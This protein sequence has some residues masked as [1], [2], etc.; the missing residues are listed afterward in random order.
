M[1]KI[2]E[3]KW[4]ESSQ[5]DVVRGEMGEPLGGR[6]G[7]NSSAHYLICGNCSPEPLDHMTAVYMKVRKVGW[8]MKRDGGEVHVD[9][10]ECPKCGMQVLR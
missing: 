9:V 8:P 5:G 4:V 7:V 2:N 3:F 10:C 6:A 1:S